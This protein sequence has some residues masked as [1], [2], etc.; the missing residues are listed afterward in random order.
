[1]VARLAGLWVVLLAGVGTAL[2][3]GRTVQ[4][5]AVV[6]GTRTNMASG[7]VGYDLRFHTTVTLL[8][9]P[10]ND[11][12]YPVV[13]PGGRY[14]HHEPFEVSGAWHL[15]EFGA[16]GSRQYLPTILSNHRARAWLSDDRQVVW[17]QDEPGIYTVDVETAAYRYYDFVDLEVFPHTRNITP[18]DEERFLVWGRPGGEASFALYAVD[19][20]AA[21]VTSANHLNPCDDVSIW[22]MRA[23]PDGER[24]AV[25]CGTQPRTLFAVDVST[26]RAVPYGQSLPRRDQFTARHGLRMGVCWVS[27]IG[28]KAR[29]CVRLPSPSWM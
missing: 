25:I 24:L 21:T 10:E 16:V 29:R 22:A 14:I 12:A 20:G 18:L 26:G 6:Y 17:P 13:S 15:W 27:V 11:E 9:H 23:A 19:L 2:G 28:G 7:L 8:D 1:M 5:H 4:M 3:V